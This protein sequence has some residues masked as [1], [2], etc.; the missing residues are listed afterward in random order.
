MK[1]LSFQAYKGF[2]SIKIN[3]HAKNKDRPADYWKKSARVNKQMSWIE[4][5]NSKLLP[6]SISKVIETHQWESV[7]FNTARLYREDSKIL[8]N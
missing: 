5:Y 8:D 3:H 1:S 2:P 6:P 4:P 7:K